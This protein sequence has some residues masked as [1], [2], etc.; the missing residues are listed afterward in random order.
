MSLFTH[1]SVQSYATIYV[2]VQLRGG[3]GKAVVRAVAGKFAGLHITL[4]SNNIVQF[5]YSPLI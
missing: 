2:D 5:I 3:S 1:I 4:L